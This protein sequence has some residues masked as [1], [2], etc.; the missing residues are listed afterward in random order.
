MHYESRVPLLFPEWLEGTHRGLI[1]VRLHWKDMHTDA[2]IYIYTSLVAFR[3]MEKGATQHAH[4]HHHH[5]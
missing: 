1:C 3:A 4:H 2:L 5:H